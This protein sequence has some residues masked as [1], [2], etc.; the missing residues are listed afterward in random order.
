LIIS[1]WLFY[2]IVL[3]S[4]IAVMIAFCEHIGDFL[5]VMAWLPWL[6]AGTGLSGISCPVAWF[7]T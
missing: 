7:T 2:G 5:K 6:W 4:L 1:R 3:K